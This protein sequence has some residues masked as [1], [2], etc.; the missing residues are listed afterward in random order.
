M[1]P[2]D[3]GRDDSTRVAGR[4]LPA[5]VRELVDA[6]CGRRCW[7]CAQANRERPKGEPLTLEHLQPLS[8]GGDNH[9]TNLVWACRSCNLGRGNR[10]KPPATPAWQRRQ[11]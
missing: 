1:N 5:S 4:D 3:W 9:Y 10:D 6:H 7:W 8:R 11:G 2:R